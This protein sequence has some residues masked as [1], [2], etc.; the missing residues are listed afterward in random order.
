MSLKYLTIMEA[1]KT[2]STDEVEKI[3]VV[4]SQRS[5]K[6]S[7]WFQTEVNE[8][9]KI[10]IYGRDWE[11]RLPK[12]DDE[13]IYISWTKNYYENIYKEIK[14]HLFM[15]FNETNVQ[16]I[17]KIYQMCDSC[18]TRTQVNHSCEQCKILQD[19]PLVFATLKD[20]KI[21]HVLNTEHVR[22]M[23]WETI[24]EWSLQ[25]LQIYKPL[26]LNYK[27]VY[28]GYLHFY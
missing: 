25:V 7:E 8:I 4:S 14:A 28:D 13:F 19:I 12:A 2:L 22:N 18:I 27:K 23:K 10:S 16:I 1:L 20:N 24:N 9:T 21:E 26:F 17:C 5:K 6:A 3:S 11:L 15:K